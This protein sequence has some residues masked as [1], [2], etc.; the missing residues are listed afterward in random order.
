MTQEKAD[1]WGGH[2]PAFPWALRSSLCFIRAVAPLSGP[3]PRKLL[4]SGASGT[5]LVASA[6]AGQR[7]RKRSGY[8]RPL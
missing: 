5:W 2:R 6:R 7:L 1:R 8:A 3:P 4:A